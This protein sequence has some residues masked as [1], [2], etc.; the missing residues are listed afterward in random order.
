M[1]GLK[2]KA[3]IV[4]GGSSGIGRSIV[5]RLCQEGCKVTFSAL[6]DIGETT[7]KEFADA[8]HDAV[9]LLCDMG[10]ARFCKDL[11]AAAR[12][13]GGPQAGRPRAP[14]G[15]SSHRGPACP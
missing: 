7:V 4:T 12:G 8:G 11:V 1:K 9:F 5:E 2:N 3:A 6:S 14:A 13:T 15:P 10:K